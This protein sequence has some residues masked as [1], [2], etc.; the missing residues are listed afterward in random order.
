[1]RGR[2][3]S[4]AEGIWLLTRRAFAPRVGS[5][6]TGPIR[7]TPPKAQGQVKMGKQLG[8]SP[9]AVKKRIDRIKGSVV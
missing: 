4:L 6:P 1:M 3:P 5:N 9:R 7:T 2:V 8:V